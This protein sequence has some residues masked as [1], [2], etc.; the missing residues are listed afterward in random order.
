[1]RDWLKSESEI[2]KDCIYQYERFLG[3]KI[4]DYDEYREIDQQVDEMVL[5]FDNAKEFFEAYPNLK[6]YKK[7][8]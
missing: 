8:I 6:K 4:K 2:D 7:L 3:R 1:M 5:D